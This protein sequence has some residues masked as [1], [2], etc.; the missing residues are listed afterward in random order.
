[1]A[2]F[3][4]IFVYQNLT[5]IH[6]ELG[7]TKHTDIKQ[8]RIPSPLRCIQV[9]NV[10]QVYGCERWFWSKQV[11]KNCRVRICDYIKIFS[12]MQIP[13]FEYLFNNICIFEMFLDRFF[14]A[15]LINIIVASTE[16]VKL[17][18][19]CYWVLKNIYLADII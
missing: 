18:C 14:V 11:E 16:H 12:W 1:M 7:W 15:F 13:S 3:F 2:F 4:A 17:L 19:Y 10:H 9:H 5:Y 6:W 8:W